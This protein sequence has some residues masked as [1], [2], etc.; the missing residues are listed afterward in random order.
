MSVLGPQALIHPSGTGEENR[1]FGLRRWFRITP[2]DTGGTFSVFEEEVP[3]GLGLP[4]HIHHDA[5]ELFVVLSGRVRFHCSGREGEAGPGA[6]VLIP[7]HAEH[8]FN[9]L[10]DARLLITLTPGN[11]IGFFRAVEAERL[12]PPDDM[13]RIAEIARDYDMAFTGLPL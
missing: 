1:A 4:R 12:R 5:Q 11:G 8:A 9:A 7:Q 10:E 3:A 2:E 13:A 6:T